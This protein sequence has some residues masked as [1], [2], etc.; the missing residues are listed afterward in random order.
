MILHPSAFQDTLVRPEKLNVKAGMG[1]AVP[2]TPLIKIFNL[3]ISL[4]TC[5]DAWRALNSFGNFENI[6]CSST[7]AA[8]KLKSEVGVVEFSTVFVG[9]LFVLF[10]SGAELRRSSGVD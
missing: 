2:T 9:S 5:E 8:T 6:Y 4:L 10:F 3:S 1:A 7:R